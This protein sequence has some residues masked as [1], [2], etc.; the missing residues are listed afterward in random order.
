M[1]KDERAHLAIVAAQGC[2]ICRLMGFYDSPAEIHHIR[3]GQGMKRA[4]HF[5]VIPLCPAHHRT[6]EN[7]IHY[8]G[9][10]AWEKRNNVIE[11]ELLAQTNELLRL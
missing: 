6:S 11:L 2:I 5:D 9:R 10:K 7:A 3:T 4:S 1:T 8:M